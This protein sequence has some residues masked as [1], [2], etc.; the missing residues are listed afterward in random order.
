MPRYLYIIFFAGIFYNTKAQQTAIDSFLNIQLKAAGESAVKKADAYN[1]TARKFMRSNMETAI[2]LSRQ[3][4]AIAN[5]ENYLSGKAMAYCNITSALERMGK[6]DAAFAVADTVVPLAIKDTSPVVKWY[7]ASNLGN[8]NRRKA[9]YPEALKFYLQAAKIAGDAKNDRLL[10]NSYNNMGIV[11]LTTNDLDRAE[12]FHAKSLVIRKAMNDTTGLYFSYDNLGIVNRERKNYDKALEYYFKAKEMA[13]AM[14]DS[15][16]I[17]FMYNDI[18]A[19]YSFKKQTAKAEKYLKASISIRERNNELHE[20]A[21]TYNYLGENY[22]RKGDLINAEASIKKAMSI[23]AAIKNNKQLMEA[24]ESLADFFS[25]NK[26][27]DSAYVYEHQFKL[28]KDSIIKKDQEEI[29]AEL[30]TKYETEKQKAR[31]KEQQLE[32]NKKNY[33]IAGIAVASML[34]LLLGYSLYKRR[35]LKQEARLQQEIILQQDMATRAVIA[36]EENERKRIASDLHDGV[37]QMM[38]AAKM[39]L[40]AFESEINF[41]TP[42]RKIAFEKIIQLVDEGCKEVRNVSHQMMPNALLKQGLA[43][44]IKEFIDKIDNSIIK[45]TLHTEGLNERMNSNTETVL[46]RVIQE[47]VNNVIKHSYANTLDIALIKDKDGIAVT[48]EDNGRGFDS[49]N[50]MNFEGIGLKNII[51]RIGY[52]KGNIEFDAAPGKGTL[53]AIH[54]PG[55]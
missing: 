35:K 36:A 2:Q 25:R 55:G 34:L 20:L 32:I 18:G 49:N 22:E 54:I 16:S 14:K 8:L 30:T 1:N 4:L 5:K 23:A 19:A 41:A 12:E 6:I 43:S 44:A 45:V 29:I 9:N 15:A 53:V 13:E 48:I 17:S 21:Y 37:G 46:Y 47:C 42:E 10:A 39:N 38:S 40:S 27:Y 7:N 52:L 28:L 33:W 31:I 24:H 51:S 3:A 11:Y 26:K 50:K